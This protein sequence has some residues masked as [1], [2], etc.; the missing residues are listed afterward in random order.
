MFRFKFRRP[1]WAP[2]GKIWKIVTQDCREMHLQTPEQ[3]K[4]PLKNSSATKDTFLINLMMWYWNCTKMDNTLSYHTVVFSSTSQSIMIDPISQGF[5]SLDA[6]IG[7]SCFP[8]LALSLWWTELYNSFDQFSNVI[9]LTQS[10]FL[11]AWNITRAFG[12][13]HNVKGDFH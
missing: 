4:R 6:K 10:I 8:I 13:I 11:L 12:K 7:K 5:F 3:L 1:L 9:F 2:M